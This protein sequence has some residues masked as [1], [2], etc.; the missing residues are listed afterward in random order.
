MMV[1]YGKYSNYSGNAGESC[2]F[3]PTRRR[4][5]FRYADL[6]DGTGD[7]QV[8]DRRTHTRHSHRALRMGAYSGRSLGPT[9]TNEQLYF[10]VGIPIAVFLMGNILSIGIAVFLTN[11][12]EKRFDR[13]DTDLREWARITMK[14]DT[15]IGRLKDKTGLGE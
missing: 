15:D 1:S 2:R 14:H 5:R 13:L 3:H 10:A 7:G 9:M 11:R 6:F 12:L 8:D 4:C